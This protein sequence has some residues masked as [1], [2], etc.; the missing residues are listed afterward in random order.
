MRSSGP[1]DTLEPNLDP[2]TPNAPGAFT[3]TVDDPRFQVIGN[4]LSLKSGVQVAASSTP[5]TLNVTS[6]EVAA[7]LSVTQAISVPVVVPDTTPPTS[8]VK[9]ESGRRE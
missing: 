7:G 9:A 6:T 5:I 4:T 1:A 8:S 2:L 3:Y